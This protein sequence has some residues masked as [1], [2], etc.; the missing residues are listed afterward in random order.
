M[1]EN[2]PCKY[3]YKIYRGKINRN[4]IIFLR[5]NN[6]SKVEIILKIYRKYI[7]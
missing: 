3:V 6:K 2:T 7:D 5:M 4:Q 1:H